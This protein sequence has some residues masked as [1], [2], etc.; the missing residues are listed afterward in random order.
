MTQ[1]AWQYGLALGLPCLGG[2]IGSRLVGPLTRRY[3]ERPVL[4][5]SGVLRTVWMGLLPLL[6]PW[7]SRTP[8]IAE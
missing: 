8:V 2:I 6:L 7:R 1:P 5:T 3:G 4:L